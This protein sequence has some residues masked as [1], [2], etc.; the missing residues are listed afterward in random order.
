MPRTRPPR[1]RYCREVTHDALTQPSDR[2]QPDRQQPDRQQPDRQQ[3]DRQQLAATLRATLPY[4]ADDST[5]SPTIGGRAAALATLAQIKPQPYRESRNFLSGDVTRLSAYLRHG[6]L[7]LAEVR[8]Y[9]LAQVSDPAET[10]KLI[11]ELAWR[12]YWQRLYGELGEGIWED[13]EPYKTGFAASHYADTLPEDIPLAETTLACMDGFSEDLRQTG[14]LHNHARLWFA[15]YIVHWRQVRWQAG[16]RWFLEH[17]I[18]GD[19][20]SN[21]LSW[22]WVA[23]TF[24]SAA[25][26]F[27]RENLERYTEGAYCKRCPHANA[28]TCLFEHSYDT[29]QEDLF[30]RLRHPAASQ[31]TP[32]SSNL[33]ARPAETPGA[34]AREGKP[35]LWHHTDSLN[36]ASAMLSA[37]IGAPAVFLWD[38]GWLMP[39]RISMK[40]VMFIAECLAEMPGPIEVRAGEPAD[41]LLAAARSAQADYMLAQRT[42]DPRLNTAAAYVSKH[43]PVVWFDP[44]AFVESSRGFDLKRFSRYWKRAGQTAM[45]PTRPNP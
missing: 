35:L 4:L 15:S 18:D 45:Q 3:P 26:I 33:Y 20:A 8:D 5:L 23:S 22:Q 28:G 30:P 32:S 36:P 19:P 11:N 10:G 37:H 38:T 2:Q 24:A 21:N 7:T 13:Q 43:L 9:A 6:V 41:E 25:Y 44:P 17:L 14:Y 34:Q 1:H 12:D 40:R 31:D 27:N 16:A 39:S 42:P 29:L